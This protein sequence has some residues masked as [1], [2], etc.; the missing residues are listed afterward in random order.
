MIVMTERYATGWTDAR[1][2]FGS[3]T[4]ARVMYGDEF[5]YKNRWGSP[6]M[7]KVKVDAHEYVTEAKDLPIEAC[8]N[9]W[10]I[11]YGNEII[12]ATETLGQGELLWEIGN[13]LWWAD[14]MKYDQA[15]DT[16]EIID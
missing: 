13:R 16:Y 12:Q 1:G 10:I 9:M 4:T 5:K 14:R 2:I 7:P 11:K 8:V 15:N 3:P 6:L